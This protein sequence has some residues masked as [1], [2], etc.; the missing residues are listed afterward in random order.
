[1]PD[2][3]LDDWAK[4]IVWRTMFYAHSS[5]DFEDRNATERGTNLALYDLEVAR[6]KNMLRADYTQAVIRLKTPRFY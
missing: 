6:A 3:I 5:L 1:M 2:F 4:A